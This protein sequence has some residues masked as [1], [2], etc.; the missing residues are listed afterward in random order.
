MSTV[1][2]KF[3]ILIACYRCKVLHIVNDAENGR[4]TIDKKII[5]WYYNLQ[6]ICK[7]QA[8]RSKRNVLL[9]LIAPNKEPQ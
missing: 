5:K 1:L 3:H 8:R 4:K 7:L 6:V 2:C 9:I